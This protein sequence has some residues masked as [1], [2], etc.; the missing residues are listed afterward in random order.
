MRC[1]LSLPRIIE[2]FTFRP[3]FE[4]EV[5]EWFPARAYTDIESG[6]AGGAFGYGCRAKASRQFYIH[7]ILELSADRCRSHGLEGYHL[8]A[9]AGNEVF[10]KIEAKDCSPKGRGFSGYPVVPER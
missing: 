8:F 10:R 4:F 1:N 6:T 5:V 2:D 9:S 3:N 7:V